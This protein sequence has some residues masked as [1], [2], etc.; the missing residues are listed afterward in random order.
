VKKVE[1][2]E[3]MFVIIIDNTVPCKFTDLF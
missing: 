3:E 2:K 1:E